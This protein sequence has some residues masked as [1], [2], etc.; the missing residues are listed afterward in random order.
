LRIPFFP[1]KSPSATHLSP[2]FSLV[3]SRRVLGTGTPK[4]LPFPG[5]LVDLFLSVPF[6]AGYL[7]SEQ[8]EGP[9][10]FWAASSCGPFFP[11]SFVISRASLW[12]GLFAGDWFHP[13][14][15][16]RPFYFKNFFDADVT[17]FR[18][19][20]DLVTSPLPPRIRSTGIVTRA[21][22]S[23]TCRSTAHPPAD[24]SPYAFDPLPMSRRHSSLPSFFEGVTEKFYGAAF[25]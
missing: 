9:M 10:T 12:P 14:S 19:L 20:D 8:S 5:F 7:S 21:L 4:T 22:S 6:S 16:C 18:S 25:F 23:L 15:V 3:L 24:F 11:L 13:V 1:Y 17:P 2:P